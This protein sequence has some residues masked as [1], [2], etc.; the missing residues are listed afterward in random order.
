MGTM[1]A[2]ILECAPAYGIWT[3]CHEWL[4]N[5][6]NVYKIKSKHFKTLFH[7]KKKKNINSLQI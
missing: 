2:A 4:V 1:G 3:V 6:P 5:W 7:T